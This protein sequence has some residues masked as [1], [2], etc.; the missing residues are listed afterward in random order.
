M[1]FEQFKLHLDCCGLQLRIITPL[2]RSILGGGRVGE[3]IYCSG[4]YVLMSVC[5][6]MCLS[7]CVYMSVYMY[8]YV[9]IHVCMNV[10]TY[11]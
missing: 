11:V 10:S 6:S 8:I 1:K 3:A 9:C 7:A 4:A 5:L 2:Y